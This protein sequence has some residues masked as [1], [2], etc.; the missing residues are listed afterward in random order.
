LDQVPQRKLDAILWQY[1]HGAGSAPPP[2]GPNASAQDSSGRDKSGDQ[3]LGQPN[4]FAQQLEDLLHKRQ[5]H[6]RAAHGG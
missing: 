1:R 5:R 4:G 3:A 6:R 2:P